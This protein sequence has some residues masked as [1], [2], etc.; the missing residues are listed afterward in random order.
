MNLGKEGKTVAAFI[1]T[2]ALV[3]TTVVL[4]ILHFP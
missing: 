4:D 2:L 3:F 1:Q